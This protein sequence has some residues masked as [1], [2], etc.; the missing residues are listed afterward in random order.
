[1]KNFLHKPK[2][3]II[4]IIITVFY[5]I[6]L[7]NLK[8][9]HDKNGQVKDLLYL[10]DINVSRSNLNIV[11][12]RE[13]FASNETIR[14]RKSIKVNNLETTLC[15]ND[16][17]KD[18]LVSAQIWKN[19]VWQE[20]ILKKWINTIQ[21]YKNCF[22]LDIGANIGQYS[23]FAAK[24][25]R[26]VISIEPFEDNILRIHK[27]AQ[28]ENLQK[29]ILVIKNVI[30]NRKNELK[31]LTSPEIEQNNTGAQ[32][33]KINSLSINH[34]SIFPKVKQKYFVK[35]ILFD[36]L[37]NYMPAYDCT[38]MKIDIDGFEPYA[39]Q[40]SENFFKNYNVEFIIMEWGV[41]ANHVKVDESIVENMMRIFVINDLYP[42]DLD[43][44]RLRPRFWR[45]WPLEVIWMKH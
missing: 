40:Y 3:I 9:Y 14:C 18:V 37:I 25:G 44:N 4:L 23:L 28:M 17:K 1:M 35:T 12:L 31:V 45:Q 38:I 22:V 42:F 15:I 20:K 30:S 21:N 43:E 39:F 2:N 8:S 32:R 26:D 33:I 5:L 13:P 11:D 16:L 7:N 27:A 34:S 36:D 10:I 29:K 41:F 6:L 19:G 24:L